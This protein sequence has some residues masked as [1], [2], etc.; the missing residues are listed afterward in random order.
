MFGNFLCQQR[1]CGVCS[2]EMISGMVVRWIDW[3]IDW[4]IDLSSQEKWLFDFVS[5]SQE[6]FLMPCSMDTFKIP[7]S[8]PSGSS[9]RWKRCVIL[10]GPARHRGATPTPPPRPCP[11]PL[12]RLSSTFSIA[13]TWRNSRANTWES[14]SIA[15]WTAADWWSWR[16][17]VLCR[18]IG[19]SRA[20]GSNGKPFPFP[21]RPLQ[22]RKGI[23]WARKGWNG[24]T[25]L[26]KGGVWRRGHGA[27]M[28][29]ASR[30][31]QGQYFSIFP[32]KFPTKNFQKIFQK[33]FQLFSTSSNIWNYTKV[34]FLRKLSHSWWFLLEMVVWRMVFG[35]CWAPTWLVFVGLDFLSFLCWILFSSY[36]GW[37]KARARNWI[38]LWPC[39]NDRRDIA[40]S[41]PTGRESRWP[42]VASFSS[43]HRATMPVCN[44]VS[45]VSSSEWF[46]FF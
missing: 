45:P 22:P 3:S 11:F 8:P 32:K 16:T 18:P 39:A 15:R 43:A 6:N 31:K 17:G 10:N 1:W 9:W 34:Y 2:V 27:G 14:A 42:A 12:S 4:L 36:R 23:R 40:W 20:C 19:C 24:R 44:E 30:K 46:F 25:P 5:S 26:N 21:H 41:V 35:E 13:I 38:V 28:D 33:N 37:W 29:S 7:Q